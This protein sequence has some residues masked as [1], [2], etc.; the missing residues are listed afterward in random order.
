MCVSLIKPL[1]ILVSFILLWFGAKGLREDQV[2]EE[3]NEII[4]RE[5]SAANYWLTVSMYISGGIAGILFSL[6][7]L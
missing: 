7:C 2:M 3:G 4:G 5:K 6:I 1:I